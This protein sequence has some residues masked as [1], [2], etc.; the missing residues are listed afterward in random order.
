ML[1]LMVASER[2]F[3]AFKDRT[4]TQLQGA[5]EPQDKYQHFSWKFFMAFQAK[6]AAAE[7]TATAVV[8]QAIGLRIQ[9]HDNTENTA[10][11]L[12]Y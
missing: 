3:A 12:F 9:N 2:G 10:W 6:A 1:W 8:E 11:I 7:F 4:V 5:A